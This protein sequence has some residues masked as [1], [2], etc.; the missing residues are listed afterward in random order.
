MYNIDDAHIH[1]KINLV[2][3]ILSLSFINIFLLLYVKKSNNLI[4]MRNKYYI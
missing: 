4:I 3:V 1:N 2:K